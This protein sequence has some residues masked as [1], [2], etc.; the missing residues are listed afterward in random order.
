MPAKTRVL[1][2]IAGHWLAHPRATIKGY[3][4]L[5]EEQAE[6]GVARNFLGKALRQVNKLNRLIGDLLDVSKI[7][8][9]KLQYRMISPAACCP[10]SAKA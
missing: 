1:I 5:L 9:G 3:L 4:Q 8:A 2:G 6:T 10:W 7:Q